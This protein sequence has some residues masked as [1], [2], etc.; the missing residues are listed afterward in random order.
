MR[1]TGDIKGQNALQRPPGQTLAAALVVL[2]AD[3]EGTQHTPAHVLWSGSSGSNLGF[4]KASRHS[5]ALLWQ[6][7]Q[8]HSDYRLVGASGTRV[9]NVTCAQGILAKGPDPLHV[10]FPQSS[11]PAALNG[12]R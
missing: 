12:I 10:S 9:T 4:Q 6:G 5:S 7:P 1:H 8:T 2:Y 11:I 3:P